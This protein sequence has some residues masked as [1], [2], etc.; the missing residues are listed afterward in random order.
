MASFKAKFPVLQ[1]LF[2]KNHRGALWVPPSG[3]RVK[4]CP[5]LRSTFWYHICCATCFGSRD[6]SKYHTYQLTQPP[7]NLRP[8]WP[9]SDFHRL[10]DSGFAPSALSIR[11]NSWWHAWHDSVEGNA[12]CRF[13]LL[14]IFWTKSRLLPVFTCILALSATYL[15]SFARRALVKSR[16]PMIWCLSNAR[17]RDLQFGA[18]SVALR[19]LVREIIPN[20]PTYPPTYM[21]QL[22]FP[23]IVWLRLRAFCAQPP[24]EILLAN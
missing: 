12:V 18:S 4:Q 10:F 17:S 20:I 9:T 8:T 6:N 3:A 14:S 21:T 11:L 13:C 23:S 15:G 7:T 2:A 19:A 24:S 5:L 16:T 22:W 1:E